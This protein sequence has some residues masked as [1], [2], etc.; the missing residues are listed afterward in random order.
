MGK[1]RRAHAKAHAKVILE[2]VN[3]ESER[4]A[5][6]NN[7]LDGSGCILRDLCPT[8]GGRRRERLLRAH[9]RAR[10]HR[11]EWSSDQQGDAKDP[12]GGWASISARSRRKFRP[13]RSHGWG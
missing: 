3:V 6:L 12:H 9:E 13:S 5:F 10:R 2:T 11:Q 8:A 4:D 7:V 1:R